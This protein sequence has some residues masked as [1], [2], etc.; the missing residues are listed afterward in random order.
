VVTKK[1][2]IARPYGASPSPYVLQA[3]GAGVIVHQ[4]RILRRNTKLTLLVSLVF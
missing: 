4:S 3:S 1:L 2:I